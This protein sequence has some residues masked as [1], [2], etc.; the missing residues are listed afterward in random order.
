VEMQ[1]HT[2]ALAVL[3]C[4]LVAGCVGA[5]APRESLISREEALKIA[6]RDCTGEWELGDGVF[7]SK[8]TR[9]WWVDMSIG[10]EGCRPSC[11]VDEDAETAEIDWGCSGALIPEED[12]D[13]TCIAPNGES[14]SLQ[15][16]I[17]I[18]E[19]S[20]C[21]DAGILTLTYECNANTGTW[22][23]DLEVRPPKAGCNPA[24][25]VDIK[26]REASV[27]W[28]CTGALPE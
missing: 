3:A 9:T 1:R 25:V 2:L 23:I 28:R 14:M 22:W 21:E 10:R 27:N 15:D 20:N 16:A 13:L 6:E 7:Y 26:T 12:L 18:I 17:D 19:G 11:V 5:G 24:C 4:I 8:D